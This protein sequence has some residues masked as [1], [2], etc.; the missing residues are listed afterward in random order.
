ME[1]SAELVKKATTKK[2]IAGLNRLLGLTRY[3]EDIYYGINFPTDNV[4]TAV[5]V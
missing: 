2:Q 5:G 3:R 1:K 4:T